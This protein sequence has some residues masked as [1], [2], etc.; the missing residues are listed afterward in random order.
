MTHELPA[1]Y[2]SELRALYHSELR[3]L[4]SKY[5]SLHV[6]LCGTVCVCV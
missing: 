4:M 3:A 2:H 1:L 6:T 5:S